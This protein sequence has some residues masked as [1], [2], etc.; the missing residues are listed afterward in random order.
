MSRLNKNGKAILPELKKT[1]G[2][3]S[4]ETQ[5]KIDSIDRKWEVIM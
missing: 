5:D 1:I 3:M 2:P 4:K